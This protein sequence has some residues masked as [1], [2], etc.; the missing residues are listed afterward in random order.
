[1]KPNADSITFS[2]GPKPNTVRAPDGT[3]REVP[4]G[5]V[6]VP[7]GDAALTRRVRAAGESWSVAEKRGR[8]VFSRGVW[9]PGGTVERVKAELETERA[10]EAHSRRR[11]ADATRRQKA[12]REYVEE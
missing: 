5:W 6:L 4:E 9:A 11:E 2:P 12:Q 8:K 7:P 10:G 1:M 3:V